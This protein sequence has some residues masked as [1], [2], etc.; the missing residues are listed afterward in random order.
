MGWHTEQGLHTASEVGLQGWK[1][2]MPC[3]AQLVQA[4]TM[5]SAVEVQ[6]SEGST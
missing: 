2:Y 1:V 5:A 4:L 6:P 3:E